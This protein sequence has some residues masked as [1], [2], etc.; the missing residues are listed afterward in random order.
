LEKAL[1]EVSMETGTAGHT[2]GNAAQVMAQIVRSQGAERDLFGAAALG[3]TDRLAALL[4]ESPEWA[5][6]RRVDGRTPLHLA[7]QGGHAAAIELLVARGAD[8][9]AP[10]EAGQTP[11]HHMVLWCTDR[12]VVGRLLAYGAELNARDRHGVTPLLLA[13]DCVWTPQHSW[14]DHQGLVEFLLERGAALDAWSATI[15]NRPEELTALLQADPA[16]VNARQRAKLSLPV[17]ATLLHHAADRGYREVAE[18]LL[19]RGADVMAVDGRGRPPLYLAAHEWATRKQRPASDVVELL[20]EHGTPLDLFAAA[21]LGRLERVRELLREDPAAVNA[22]DE[23]GYTPLHLAVWNGKLEMAKLLL[24]HGA[25]MEAANERGETPLALAGIYEAQNGAVI[26]LLRARGA[27]CDLFTA[28]TLADRD[29]AAARLDEEPSRREA[30]NRYGLTPV[31]RALELAPWIPE[32]TRR[33]SHWDVAALLLERGAA[34]ELDLFAAAALGQLDQVTALLAT[35][36]SRVN[37]RHGWQFAPLHWAALWGHAAVVKAL[38]ARGAAIEARDLLRGR[39]ALHWAAW[40]GHAGVAELLLSLG[41]GHQDAD[42]DGQTALHL[43]AARGHAPVAALLLDSGAEVHARNSWSGTPLHAAAHGGQAEVARLLLARGASLEARDKWY[44]TPLHAAAWHGR[45]VMVHLLLANGADLAATN[46]C[47]GTPLHMAAERGHSDVV[48]LLLDHGAAINSPSDWG[49]TPLHVAARGGHA[50]TVRLLLSRGAEVNARNKWQAT[51]LHWAAEGGYGEVVDV[52]LD[53]GAEVEVREERGRTPLHAAVWEGH[54]AVVEQL[55]TR[56]ADLEAATDRG[57]TP[58]HTA[59][60]AGRREMAALLLARGAEVNAANRWR[61]VPLHSAA[62]HGHA[63]LAELLLGSGAV[64]DARER[65]GKTPR[66][67]ALERGHQE[68][69]ELLSRHGAAA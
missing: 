8:V 49:R 32:G 17:G 62:W 53:H 55:L 50:D 30:R 12:E 9:N 23:G 67:Q 56:G 64:V 48:A 43:A 1:E 36:P 39:T 45:A 33:G 19:E 4:S 13:A 3:E 58:L 7:A 5:R 42:N 47:Y 59:I 60:Q 51:P 11:L 69:V 24:E 28:I 57:N 38:L 65:E 68:V 29:E 63:E 44:R 52:L 15:L 20:L 18:V 16:L 26:D 35:E 66:Q 25:E 61:N 27:Y 14:G 34:V 46:Q 37:A 31:E 40:G 41:I 22:R 54:E 10:D 6:A 21:V 2:A